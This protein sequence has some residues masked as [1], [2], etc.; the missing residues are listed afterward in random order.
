MGVD[1]KLIRKILR[2]REWIV[3]E[4]HYWARTFD[5]ELDEEGEPS[6]E[7]FDFIWNLAD[8]LENDQCDKNDYREILFHIYQINYDSR[9]IKGWVIG[10]DYGF[11]I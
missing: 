4:L 6:S 9:V 10:R 8:K 2:Q 5:D 3:D 7:A 1:K 11:Q